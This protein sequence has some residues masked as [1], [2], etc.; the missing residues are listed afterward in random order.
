M[1][2]SKLNGLYKSVVK[3]DASWVLVLK[4]GSSKDSIGR[5]AC[6]KLDSG[7]HTVFARCF[8]DGYHASMFSNGHYAV[9]I[10]V[11]DGKAVFSIVAGNSFILSKRQTKKL[12]K[13]LEEH[14]DGDSD[15]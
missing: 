13:I 11:S 1:F 2:K 6:I 9:E 3:G 14:L 12:Y 8:N 15:K 5:L 10:W 7:F 4:Y